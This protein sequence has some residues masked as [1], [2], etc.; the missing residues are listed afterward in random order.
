MKA[1]EPLIL[2]AGAVLI[3]A[4][5]AAITAWHHRRIYRSQYNRGWNAGRDF[6]IRQA[7]DVHAR[8]R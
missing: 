1:L 3:A 6:A 8:R 5:S 2:I 4:L 7:H